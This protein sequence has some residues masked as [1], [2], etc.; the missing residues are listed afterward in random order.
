MDATDGNTL[1][2]RL[3][4][5][6]QAWGTES[7]FST[8]DTKSEPSKSGVIGMLACAL[9]L[10]RHAPLDPFR[11]VRMGVRV[12]RPGILL[13]DYH[14]VGAG[15]G[16][17]SAQGKIKKTQA[18]GELEAVVSVRWYLADASFLVALMG[19]KDLLLRCADALRDPVWPPF[20][21]R[22][23]CPPAVPPLVGLQSHPD[24]RAALAAH[25][26]L[27]RLAEVDS[28]LGD[29]LRCVIEASVSDTG[30]VLRY[31]VPMSFCPQRHGPRYVVETCVPVR[32]GQPTQTPCAS[33]PARRMRYDSPAWHSIRDR[34]A[35]L[36]CWLCG[37]CKL[38]SKPIHHLTYARANDERLEDLVA[39]CRLCHDAVTMLETE[40]GMGQLRIDP[41]DPVWRERVLAKRAAI[42]RA[43]N[44]RH[45]AS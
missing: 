19:P 13:R 36:D 9:G 7:R 28:C 34:R 33:A 24:L 32:V 11:D 6:F 31:D 4:G 26:W 42:L 22:K 1:L 21:G 38:P 12:D 14:T 30:A 45:A 17:M 23:C 3:E 41:R 44:P 16:V 43:R 2:M 29:K 5:P 39:L 10:P 8:R 15:L 40:S 25:P 35:A 37:F 27:P 20:L 18:T